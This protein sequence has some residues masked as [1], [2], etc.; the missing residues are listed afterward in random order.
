VLQ[1]LI[2]GHSL[3]GASNLDSLK[4]KMSQFFSK[5]VLSSILTGESV[6]DLPHLN[7]KTETQAEEF[8]RGY[9]FDPKVPDQEAKLWYYYRRAFVFITEKLGVPEATLPEV[10]RQREKIG[11]AAQLLLWA[12]DKSQMELSAWTCALLR[13][14][15]VFVHSENDLFSSFSEEIQNQV[16]SSFQSTIFT[17]GAQGVQYLRPSGESDQSEWIA[18]YAFEVKSFKSSSSSVLKLLAK[19]EAYALSVLDKLGLRFVTYSLFDS[20]RVLQFLIRE[21]LISYP[22]IMSDQTTNTL[23]PVNFFLDLL[24]KIDEIRSQK[25]DFNSAVDELLVEFLKKHK[26]RA[27]FAKKKNAF[28][29]SEHRFIKF[30]NRKLIRIS[31]GPSFFYPFEIQIMDE[32]AYRAAESGPTHHQAYK[33]RQK[34]AARRRAL[35]ARATDVIETGSDPIRRD[36]L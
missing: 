27:R 28:S 21:N 1:I 6:L 14:A 16:L 17:E 5:R 2:L 20:F 32:K 29:S 23:Y 34:A 30:I 33:E 18:L 13:V 35:G 26:N 22:H 12:S 4:S 11:S 3:T 24:P 8:L 36:L 7:I 9:G 25:K 15:H 10:L 19:K 31:N